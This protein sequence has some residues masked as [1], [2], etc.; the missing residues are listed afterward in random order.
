MSF[1]AE[2]AGILMA[3]KDAFEYL[4]KN[5]GRDEVWRT[6][7]PGIGVLERCGERV[8]KVS[9]I[10]QR[11]ARAYRLKWIASCFEMRM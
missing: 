5:C 9:I 2:H 6:L 10:F 3:V 8:L 7:R 4:N 1:F 11:G